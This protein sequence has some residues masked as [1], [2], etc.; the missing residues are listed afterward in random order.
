VR[1]Y[2]VPVT[3]GAF[4][5]VSLSAGLY[6]ANRQR[7]VAERRFS[8]LRQLARQVIFDTYN[9][10]DEFPGAIN[11]QTKLVS[12]ATQYL[13]GLGADAT[14]DKQLALEVAESYIQLARLQG[15]PGWNNLGRYAEA[16][17]NLRKAEKLLDPI[18]AADPYNRQAIYLSANAAHDRATAADA[19]GQPVQM[20]AAA[21]KVHERFD[22]LVRLGNLTRK[23]IN[24]ATYI[25]A[26][27]AEQHIRLHRFQDA[28]RY[29]Q[30]G[31]EI[32]QTNSTIAG[33]R[34]ETFGVLARAFQYLGDFQGAL[35]AIRG[36]RNETEKYRR[37][38]T[39]SPVYFWPPYARLILS[40][41]RSQEGLILAEDGGIDLNQPRE[42]AIL[43]REAYEAVEENATK[44][45]KD[46]LS[47]GHVAEDGLYLGNVL[48]QSSPR[49]ALE[50]YDHG[51]TRIREVPS[52]IQARR[53]EASLLAASSYAARS[54]HREHDARDRIDA[55]F[56]LLRDTKDYPS[57]AV[58]PGSEADATLRALADHYAE[59][60]DPRKALEAYQDLR[61]R[62]MKS[63]PDP[64]ND[65][66]NA[67]QISQLDRA[68]AALL[69]RVGGTDEAVSLDQNRLE[70]WR[71]WD[72]KLPNNPFVQRQI[73]GK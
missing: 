58:K 35:E 34:A 19:A 45:P 30:A 71:H 49:Q 18:L 55:A 50:L 63:H 36:A 16:V 48:R 37:Y 73:A 21:V 24:S 10:I 60:G 38:E 3:A 26:G 72:R 39:D 14:R 42:A 13:A 53:Q 12:T 11:A 41:V 57:E 54:L 66:L 43:F 51:L 64:Q 40:A 2:W 68:L 23:E 65:L 44:E 47:R 15:V 4:V 59:T 28:L 70:L 7:L 32:S 29:A 27:L 25:Y 31:I 8:Q 61:G 33:P 1:R 17:E 62:I 22:Q 69:R 6:V 5:I 20:T 52:D 56:R 9:T 67:A 46:Y